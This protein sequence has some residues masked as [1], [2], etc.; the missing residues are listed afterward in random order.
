[1]FGDAG[2]IRMSDV[3]RDQLGTLDRAGTQRDAR[4]RSARVV[5]PALF[6][7]SHF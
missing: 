3:R 2:R 7:N 5:H 6:K 4:D 1:M